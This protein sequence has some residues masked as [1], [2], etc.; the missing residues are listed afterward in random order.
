MGIHVTIGEAEKRLAELLAA[1][2]RGEEVVLLREG[3]RP[4]RL[5]PVEEA[6]PFADA[7]REAVRAR[8]LAAIGAWR[9]EF[10]AFDTSLA[11]L[12]ADR[13]DE[14]ERSGRQLGPSD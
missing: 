11:A 14:D 5:V 9:A 2:T 3:E 8:R 12:K 13:V 6:P 1:A 7:D 4:V 10:A